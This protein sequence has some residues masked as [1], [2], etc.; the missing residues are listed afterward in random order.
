[1]DMDRAGFGERHAAGMA[2]G[3]SGLALFLAVAV[4][5]EGRAF[6]FCAVAIVL[7]LSHWFRR[8]AMRDE[9]RRNEAMEDERDAAILA[10]ADRAFR[11]TASCWCVLLAL[12]L[13]S[14]AF[15]DALPQHRF[16]I[17]ALLLLGV[18]VANIAGHATAWRL[19][20]ND[21][22]EAA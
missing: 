20:R 11:A 4:L 14:D 5:H 3:F 8:R 1:M 18:I 12:A 7:V 10:R 17:P 13:C 6:A 19:H 15:R 22:R 21:R 16:A 9:Q 2:A